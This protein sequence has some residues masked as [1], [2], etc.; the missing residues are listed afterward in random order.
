MRRIRKTFL[1][2]CENDVMRSITRFVLSVRILDIVLYEAPSFAIAKQIFQER[3]VD[4]VF[5]VR[6]TRLDESIALSSWM[7]M[8]GG[9]VLFLNR[10]NQDISAA[11][12]LAT[13][14]MTS[15]A[16]TAEWIERLR[17][18]SVRKRGPKKKLSTGLQ[19][20]AS[21]MKG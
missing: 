4:V 18:L 20:T 9:R 12:V 16:G 3:S 2:Y 5:I 21:S 1:L 15:M 10:C 13:A 14:Y 11:N 6:S 8:R 7:M 19:L 17:I